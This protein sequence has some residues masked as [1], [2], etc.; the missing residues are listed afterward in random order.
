VLSQAEINQFHNL[1]DQLN[2]NP[3]Y[4][5]HTDNLRDVQF[6]F[7]RASETLSSVLS[8]NYTSLVDKESPDPK[9]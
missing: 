7:A 8:V 5:R 6:L 3:L 4:T 1:L 2:R 9:K